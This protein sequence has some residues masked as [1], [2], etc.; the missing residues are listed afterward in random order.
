MIKRPFEQWLFEDVQ[1]VF[2]IKRIK[3]HQT[4]L[5]WLNVEN[6]PPLPPNITRLQDLIDNRIESWNEDE[7]KMNFIAPLLTEINYHYL[8]HYTVFSQRLFTLQTD[9]VEAT[10]RVEW[11]VSTGEQTP[12]RPFFFLHEYKP[13]KNSGNDPL[14]QLLMAMI[15]AQILNETPQTPLQGCYTIGRFWFFVILVGKEYSVSKAY[16]ATQTDDLTLMVAILE[17]VKMYIHQVLGLPYEK[18]TVTI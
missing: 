17:K 16:D 4:L 14:G 3:N 2:G 8:P 12:K 18:K 7:L 6:A 11:L 1:E 15:E 13:E 9:T 5:D 10:G